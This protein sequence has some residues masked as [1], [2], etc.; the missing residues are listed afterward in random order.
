MEFDR[1]L[2]DNWKKG[3]LR[4]KEVK[5]NTTLDMSDESDTVKR[6]PKYNRLRHFRIPGI[7]G[8]FCYVHIKRDNLRFHIYADEEGGR[9]Y[10]PYIGA[11]LELP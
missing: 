6:N 3:T 1:Y 8:R 9:V 11:H 5:D 7:G 4:I 2:R 10:V